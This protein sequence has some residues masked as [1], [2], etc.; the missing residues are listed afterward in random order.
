MDEGRKRAVAVQEAVLRNSNY[1]VV[2]S[3]EGSEHLSNLFCECGFPDC[4][5]RLS[6]SLGDYDRVRSHPRRF[7]VLPGHDIP[8]AEKVVEAHENWN[9]V[10]KP[11]EVHGVTEAV[12][13]PD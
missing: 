2:G 5:E 11:P 4:R 7:L 9:V 10:E 6:V 3:Q 12:D 1:R 8:G 13:E